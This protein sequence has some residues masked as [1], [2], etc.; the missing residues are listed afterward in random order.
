VGSGRGP[1]ILIGLLLLTG[2][3]RAAESPPAAAADQPFE[4]PTV[5][6]ADGLV[7]V[8]ADEVP[9][10]QLLHSIAD[11]AEVEL[12]GEVVE[13]RPVTVRLDGV[14]IR[15][16]ID[17][18]LVDQN[19]TMR[20]RAD[21]T[22]EWITLRGPSMER[23]TPA[24]RRRPPRV[25]NL[26]TQLA[27]TQIAVPPDLQAQMGGARVSL[28]R[29]LR[30][31]IR[32]PGPNVR[33]IAM[34]MFLNTVERNSDMRAALRGMNPQAI[35]SFGRRYLGNRGDELV[36]YLSNHARDPAVRTRAKTA[37]A[38]IDGPAGG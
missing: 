7:T 36:R 10:D 21:G 18:L 6:F 17:R 22:L 13:P 12:H 20:Y 1:V 29:F 19:F 23:T 5:S 16:A 15:Q 33:R 34:Q 24:Q 2:P 4:P 31:I 26:E 35:Q 38:R 37:V 32:I 28:S 27:R 11:E 9:L 30:G 8:E 14:P 25:Q 3:V